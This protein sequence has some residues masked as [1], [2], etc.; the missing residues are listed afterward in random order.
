[1][2]DLY[3]KFPDPTTMLDALRPLGMTT[4]DEDGI[5]RLTQGGHQF[6]LSEVGTIP[7]RGGWHLNMRVID[8]DFDVSALEPWRV[9]P[10]APVCVWA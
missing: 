9:Y 7:G 1:M 5:E 8:P 3:L 10:V 4:T 6:A 2:N